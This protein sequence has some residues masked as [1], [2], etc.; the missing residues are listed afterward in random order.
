MLKPSHSYKP[1]KAKGIALVIG[2]I[3][4]VLLTLMATT[5]I[6]VST[7]Q[8]RT[9]GNSRDYIATLDAAEA[10]LRGCELLL[11]GASVPPIQNTAGLYDFVLREANEDELWAT[12]DWSSDGAVEV[13]DSENASWPKEP[14]RCFVEAY[15]LVTSVAG[16]S[17]AAGRALEE[18]GMYR[19]TARALGR[20]D[21]TTVIL[22]STYVR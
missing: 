15:G 7:Q 8:E 6:T 13:V 18:S 9:S 12:I 20:F 17:I 10:G 2:L 16:G 11:Q 14:P 1:R 4:L 22:Q 21:G 3:F 19:V 5:G